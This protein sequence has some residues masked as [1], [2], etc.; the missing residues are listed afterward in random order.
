MPGIDSIQYDGENYDK[1]VELIGTVKA[2]K[3]H[4]VIAEIKVPFSAGDQLEFICQSGTRHQQRLTTLI[5]M[6][7][8]QVDKVPQNSVI[9]FES[10]VL[11]D[12]YDI[13]RKPLTQ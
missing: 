1:N 2:V 13:I 9:Q 5:N 12:K 4:T 11:M 3:G 7:G 10:T 6:A 8:V